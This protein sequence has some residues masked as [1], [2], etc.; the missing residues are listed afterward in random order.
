M[1]RSAMRGEADGHDC[2]PDSTLFH[3]GHVTTPHL[4]LSLAK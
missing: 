1:K 2:F 4:G 3:P